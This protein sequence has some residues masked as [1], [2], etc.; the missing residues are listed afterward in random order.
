MTKA[1]G[2]PESWRCVDC[3]ANTA[4]GLLGRG[5]T[6]RALSAQA[7]MG[8][9]ESERVMDALACDRKAGLVAEAM[10]RSLTKRVAKLEGCQSACKNCTPN[11]KLPP[12]HRRAMWCSLMGPPAR[13]VPSPL[14]ARRAGDFSRYNGQ[15]NLHAMVA[16]WPFVGGRRTSRQ[17]VFF[18]HISTR[19]RTSGGVRRDKAPL[20]AKPK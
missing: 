12:S 11:N 5:D 6:E 20:A 10:R 19:M 14:P 9:P 16:T 3:G 8:V 4:P 18:C 1:T 15:P 7:A 2:I 17:S 13:L